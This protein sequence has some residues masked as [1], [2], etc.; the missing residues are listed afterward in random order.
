MGLGTGDPVLA[1]SD[2][3]EDWRHTIIQFLEGKR[4]ES[5]KEEEI[6][7]MSAIFYYLINGML[8]RKAFLPTDA[9]C[10]SQPEGILVVREAHE[11]GCAEHVGARSLARKVARAGFYWMRKK[12][13]KNATPA[14]NTDIRYISP[15][16]R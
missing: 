14:R 1:I 7:E 16:Q 4:P 3:T 12:W 15:P 13:Y 8:F 11:G 2:G 9:T 10:L 6:L 5:K